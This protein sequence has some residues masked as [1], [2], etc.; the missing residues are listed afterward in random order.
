[1]LAAPSLPIGIRRRARDG[2]R[3]ARK[4]PRPPKSSPA[5][6]L[7]GLSTTVK[8]SRASPTPQLAATRLA[9][10]IHRDDA[11][12]DRTNPQRSRRIRPTRVGMRLSFE[13]DDLLWVDGSRRDVMVWRRHRTA[14][15]LRQVALGDH[16]SRGALSRNA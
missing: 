12:R 11:R 7:I 16:R 13:G 8:A 9:R 3:T 5:K 2:A 4:R 6:I 15:M 1:M 10:S 14:T